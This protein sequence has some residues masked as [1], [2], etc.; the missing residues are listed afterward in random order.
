MFA[1]T[2]IRQDQEG[3]FCLNDLHKAAGGENKH[4]PSLW[5]KNA[6]TAAF[7]EAASKA[8]IPAIQSKQQLG[9]FV[10]KELVYH[11]ATWISPEFSLKVIRAYDGM[12]CPLESGGQAGG[13]TISGQS[14]KRCHCWRCVFKTATVSGGGLDCRA[15]FRLGGLQP[16]NCYWAVTTNRNDR[17]ELTAVLDRGAGG[18]STERRDADFPS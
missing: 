1:N 4:R 2:T 15:C 18:R 10:A 14:S 13:S 16:E 17:E 6:Q 3:R 8:G 7:I 12:A 11:Y 9:T 5:L